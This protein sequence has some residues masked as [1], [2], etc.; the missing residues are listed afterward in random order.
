MLREARA[1]DEAAIEAFLAR[2]AETSMFL[3]GNLAAHGLFDRSHAHGTQ[4]W[5][6]E[7]ET[8][9]ALT[10]V[11]GLSNGGFALLQAPDAPDALFTAFARAVAGRDLAGITGDEPQ[12]ARLRAAFALDHARFTLDHP[13]P[14]YR[15]DL[16]ALIVPDRPGTLRPVTPDDRELLFRWNRAYGA[17]LQ[18]T[19][20]ERLDEET[21][22]RVERALASG[23]VRLLEV[24][25]QPVAMTAF[26]AR[27]PD[28]VQIGGVYTPPDLRGHGY[29]RRAVALHLA[30]ARGDGVE[31]AILFASGPAACRAYEAIGFTHIGSYALAILAAPVVVAPAAPSPPAG[32]SA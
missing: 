29:A 4:F 24:D 15:L 23:V 13:E 20:P 5:L 14:L 21:H 11:F 18:M 9:G 12:V 17:E 31:T 26:N 27:L 1:G 2:H 25:G 6:A 30:E 28:M 16:A 22:A 7:P 3:R 8:G 10:A 19:A 32:D